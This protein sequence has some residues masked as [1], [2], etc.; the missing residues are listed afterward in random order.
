M[1]SNTTS[2]AKSRTGRPAK[3]TTLSVLK[4]RGR[5]P[6]KKT[7]AVLLQQGLRPCRRASRGSDNN[8]DLSRL[9]S[10]SFNTLVRPNDA[11]NVVRSIGLLARDVIPKGPDG[12]H[13]LLI[14]LV[15]VY[16]ICRAA[17]G[18]SSPV[19]LSGG[20]MT[21]ADYEKLVACLNP[22]A[23]STTTSEV[24]LSFGRA[25]AGTYCHPL[26]KTGNPFRSHVYMD[27]LVT[28]WERSHDGIP[29]HLLLATVMLPLATRSKTIVK[30]MLDNDRWYLSNPEALPSLYDVMVHAS[31]LLGDE[32]TVHS[33]TCRLGMLIDTIAVVYWRNGSGEPIRRL[34][35]AVSIEQVLQ[36]LTDIPHINRAHVADDLTYMDKKNKE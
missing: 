7:L 31:T 11:H 32:N 9:Q 6:A 29:T 26:W 15:V 2:K 19:A 18:C 1:G 30:F 33:C 14:R 12:L 8:R 24:P 28:W 25:I 27:M 22:L 10:L 4:S 21:L 23:V 5:R 35:A 16:M 34:A 17:D 13:Q 20:G 36:T 3:K